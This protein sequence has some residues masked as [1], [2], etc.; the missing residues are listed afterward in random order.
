MVGRNSKKSKFTYQKARRRPY[1]QSC[2]RRRGSDSGTACSVFAATFTALRSRSLSSFSLM[3]WRSACRMERHANLNPASISTLPTSYL[4]E[5]TLTLPFMA[6]GAARVAENLLSRCFLEADLSRPL[7]IPVSQRQVTHQEAKMISR[8]LLLVRA[9][10]SVNYF[11]PNTKFLD[12]NNPNPDIQSLFAVR[13]NPS[14][15]R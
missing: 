1:S 10:S 12:F 11:L 9:I 13:E 8:L 4:A 2:S 15:D 3:R 5:P 14:C 7:I 6:T